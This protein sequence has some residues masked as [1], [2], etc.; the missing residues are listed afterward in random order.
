MGEKSIRDLLKQLRGEERIQNPLEAIGFSPAILRLGLS[1]DQLYNY[2]RRSARVLLSE[3]HPDAM[4]GEV[5]EQ[6]R[7]ASDALNLLNDREAFRQAMIEFREVRSNERAEERTL[8]EQIRTLE[9]QN[10]TLQ[11]A[12]ESTRQELE[13]ER[14]FRRWLRRYFAG[15]GLH[16]TQHSVMPVALCKGLTVLSFRFE[17]AN[18]APVE[19]KLAEAQAYYGEALKRTGSDHLLENDANYL[20]GMAS[21]HNLGAIQIGELVDRA[22]QSSSYKVPLI[23]WDYDLAVR[24]LGMPKIISLTQASRRGVIS[25]SGIRRLSDEYRHALLLLRNRFGEEYVLA[26]DIFLESFI[27]NGQLSDTPSVLSQKRRIYVVGTTELGT[28]RLVDPIPKKRARL[29]MH[30]SE[31]LHDVPRHEF[32]GG[33]AGLLGCEPILAPGRA[34][35]SMDAHTSRSVRSDYPVH[36]QISSFKR[37]REEILNHN[38][39][40]FFLAH[41]VLGAE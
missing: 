27:M 2:C 41:I 38:G 31:L 5:L 6:A 10:T 12:H 29:T 36:Q 18:G 4:D 7:R 13:Q 20:N 34:V 32:S 28:V 21:R 23:H 17:F 25:D 9:R 37:R 30:E 14:G 22:L 39:L 16:I 11:E 40:L 35:I 24:E 3:V 19:D 15:H 8:R 33:A 1:E 26:T